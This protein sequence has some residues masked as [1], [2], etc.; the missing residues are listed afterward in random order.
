M[1]SRL[2][3][4]GYARFRRNAGHARITSAPAESTG[5]AM[6]NV[7]PMRESSIRHRVTEAEWQTRVDLA[8]FYRL[9][10]LYGMSEIIFNH[11][12]ARVPGTDDEFLINPYGLM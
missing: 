4:F 6:Q 10:A 7:S 11:V 8:A 2:A 5:G 1:R 12:T 3:L 9:V